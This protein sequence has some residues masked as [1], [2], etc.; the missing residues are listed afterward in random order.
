AVT[1][2]GPP[3]S[4]A[5]AVLDGVVVHEVQP[6]RPA[7]ADVVDGNRVAAAAAGNGEGVVGRHPAE[8]QGE[9]G[10]VHP[11]DGLAE[12]HRVRHAGGVGGGA[13]RGGAVD[14]DH[15][16]GGLVD[17]VDLAGGVAV[18]RAR[19]AQP[20]GG[21]VDDRVVIHHVEAQ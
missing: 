19:A 6:Q 20:V 2:A 3:E 16:G 21:G 15:G 1:C 8:R 5:D 7:A 17:G 10:R 12:G 18:A 14:G 11:G 9:V 13:R 4:V